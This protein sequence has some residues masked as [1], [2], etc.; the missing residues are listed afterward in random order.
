M[1]N[2]EWKIRG[3]TIENADGDLIAVSTNER[4]L[5]AI[6]TIPAAVDL[7]KRLLADNHFKTKDIREEVWSIIADLDVNFVS[8]LDDE[9]LTTEI[10]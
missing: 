4:V 8:G 10:E 3:C 6:S 5:D 9:P 2:T 1:I 7:F